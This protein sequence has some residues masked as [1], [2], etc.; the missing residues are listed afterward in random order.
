MMKM[1]QK[2]FLF[3]FL[4]LLLVGIPESRA[5]GE[6]VPS[7]IGRVLQSTGQVFGRHAYACVLHGQGDAAFPQAADADANDVLLPV[8]PLRLFR[9][10]QEIQQDLE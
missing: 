7:H 8:V 4:I 1:S 6:A 3:G 2:L 10:A 5:D 9:V